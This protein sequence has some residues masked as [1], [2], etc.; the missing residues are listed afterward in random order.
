MH[1]RRYDCNYSRRHFLKATAA[2]AGAGVLMP[3]WQALAATGDAT[4]AYPD[5]LLSIEGYTKGKIKTG[6]E[7]TAANV[8]HVKD[9][10]EPIRYEQ[11]VKQG[12]KLK[13]APTT[14]DLMRLSPWEYIEATLRNAGKAK[15]DAKGNVVNGADGQPWIGGNPFP[16]AKTGIELFAAQTLSW[17]RHDASFYCCLIDT[18]DHEGNI[19]F[20]YSAGWAE[21]ATVSRVTLDPKPYWPEHKDKLRFQSVFFLSP[22]N[23]RGT[24]FL[25]IWDYDHS[26]FP[27]LYG[28][29]AEFRRIRQFPTD[30]RFE[31]LVPGATLY[32][33]DAW[34]A[35]DPLHTWGNYQIV[36]RG[37]FLAGVSGGWNAEHP[38]WEHK[39]HGGPKGNMFWDT[40]VE[41]V[42]EAIIVE[43][44]PVKFPR[45]PVSKKRV[46]FD[47]RN[48][49]VIGMTTY[50]RKGQP[51]RSF[52]GAY[53]IYES[54]GKKVM[55]G[56]HPYWSWT[57]VLAS[58]IQTNSVTRLQQVK[59]LENIHVSGAN[60]PTIYDRYLTQ[61][62][63]MHLGAV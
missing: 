60:D 1:V 3:L 43:A 63:L 36:G 19:K 7:I 11:I 38:N 49:T 31:P 35:G 33:S 22:Q 42:P 10:L 52:D 30:Q 47:A 40:T 51:Y 27:M 2:G 4:K 44:E 48:Q 34:A 56:K 14:T 17:G 46:W 9:L 59:S 39:T 55:D 57:H 6:D 13:V 18:V 16:A 50:D 28:Y 25:N 32:L 41:L 24:S 20:K 23:F 12:R 58:D 5:E 53:S 54:G 8:E 29:V 45:A 26:T 62:A 61:K 15:F 37:P 21:L